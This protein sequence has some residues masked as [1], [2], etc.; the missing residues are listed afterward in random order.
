MSNTN[1]NVLLCLRECLEIPRSTVQPQENNT[2]H[3]EMKCDDNCSSIHPPFH[4]F[5]SV[6]SCIH[7]S[8]S[9]IHESVLLF[10]HLLN[11]PSIHP[12]VPLSI[13]Q[14][15]VSLS[16]CQTDYSFIHS[17]HASICV[18]IHFFGLTIHP[19]ATH[20]SSLLPSVHHSCTHLSISMYSC[21]QSVR[22]SCPPSIYPSFCPSNYFPKILTVQFCTVQFVATVRSVAAVWLGGLSVWSF[23]IM[24][25]LYTSWFH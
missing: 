19:P 13:Q 16:M 25:K 15:S 22:L 5:L 18:S 12:F 1:V 2:H 6:Y 4:P 10:I 24:I 14:T 17:F 20:A 7:Y 3:R 23:F 8:L 11:H 21:V 9:S